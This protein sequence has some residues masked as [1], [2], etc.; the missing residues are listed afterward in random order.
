MIQ[1]QSSVLVLSSL[2]WRFQ[3]NIEG[4]V[5]SSSETQGQS[6]FDRTGLNFDR[7]YY[8]WGESAAFVATSAIGYRLSSLLG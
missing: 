5:G 2:K 8:N 4:S 6:V 3:Y 1:P 7:F